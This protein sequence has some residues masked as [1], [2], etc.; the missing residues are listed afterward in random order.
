MQMILERL[1]K[2]HKF[3]KQWEDKNIEFYVNVDKK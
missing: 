1:F 3:I 2:E